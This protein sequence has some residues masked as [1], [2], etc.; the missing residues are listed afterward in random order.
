M[1]IS[2]ISSQSDNTLYTLLNSSAATATTAASASAD[3]GT[4]APAADSTNSNTELAKELA[5]LLK[6]L[7]AGDLKGA[8]TDLQNLKASLKQQ[9]ATS[10]TSL[11]STPS[12]LNQLVTKLSHDLTSGST[13]DALN[14]IATYLAASGSSTGNLVNTTT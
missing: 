14:D 9:D 13:S 3:A 10:S 1:S 4:S 11:A 6:A 8:Q 7:A 2:A 5:A 12:P